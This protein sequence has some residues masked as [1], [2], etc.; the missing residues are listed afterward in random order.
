VTDDFLSTTY[1]SEGQPQRRYVT[2]HGDHRDPERTV[3]IS[4]RNAATRAARLIAEDPHDSTAIWGG[5]RI[6][7]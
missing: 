1:A 2:R 6:A 4:E 7:R 3:I 5:L